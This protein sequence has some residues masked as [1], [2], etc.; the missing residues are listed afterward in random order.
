MDIW[1]Q[2]AEKPDLMLPLPEGAWPQS[3]DVGTKTNT[4]AANKNPPKTWTFVS[5]VVGTCL[6]N[7]VLGPSQYQ[8]HGSARLSVELKR[9]MKAGRREETEKCARSKSHGCVTT[10]VDDLDLRW[11]QLHC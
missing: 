9:G 5:Q 7:G 1:T 2:D 10:R 4:A 3:P 11:V 6:H 8:S